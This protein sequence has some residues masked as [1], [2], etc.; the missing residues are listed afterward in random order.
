MPVSPGVTLRSRFTHW[1]MKPVVAHALMLNRVGGD[2]GAMGTTRSADL[3]KRSYFSAR[4][5]SFACADPQAVLGALVNHLPFALESTQREAWRYEIE[6]LQHLTRE[7]GE[8]DLFLEFL[9]PRMGRRVDAVLLYRGMVFVLEYKVGASTRSN[10]A[11]GQALGY[12]LDLKNFH[13]SSHGLSIVPIVIATHAPVS[14]ELGMWSADQI[15]APVCVN[16]DGLGA[17]IRTIVSCHAHR[18]VDGAAWAYGRYKPTPTIIEAAQALYRGHDVEEIS[19]SEAGAENLSVTSDYIA[20]VIDHAKETGR[21]AVCFVTGVPGS[22]KTLAGLNVANVR[23]RAHDDE[24]AVFLSGNGPLVDVLREALT[25]DALDQQAHLPRAERSTRQSEQIK[26][27]AFIQNIHHFR[28]EYL[29]NTQAPIE[30]VIVFDEAQRAWDVDQTSKFMQTKRGQT[31]FA[32][33]EPHFLLS[34]MDRHPDWCAVVC[35]IGGGQE[36]NTGEAGLVE[37][38]SALAAHFPGWDVHVPDQLLGQEYLLAGAGEAAMARLQLTRT[39]A[40]HLAVS[41]RSFRAEKLSTFIGAVIDGNADAAVAHAASLTNYPLYIT[42]DLAI[43]RRWLRQQRRASERAGLLAS[44]N[45]L[46]LKPD[47]VFVKAKIEPPTWFLNDSADIRSSDMLEDV[48]TEFD[49]QG[50]EL[51]WACVCWDANLRRGDAG[52]ETMS[53]KGTSWQRVSDERRRAYLLNSYRVLLTRAR[54]GMVVFVPP[55]DAADLT[56]AP[57]DYDRIF[58]FLLECGFVRLD[59]GVRQR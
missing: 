42:R 28:D 6:H 3:I 57:G 22:G 4:S 21:R 25:L 41:I 59:G 34:V 29:E 38:L 50:L 47:G 15:M 31:G 45:A 49:V 54:Q 8:F 10:A 36:I 12:A 39:P 5:T 14:D 26:A 32:M 2:L 11:I 48:G 55:G 18:D 17:V 9:I 16:A 35:L 51:D 44:S 19:R 24:H 30:K 46:R 33:S 52:W 7:L 56:R 58:Q 53:F 23:M 40:L 37:W 20:G 27:Q 43:A 1:S 13:E